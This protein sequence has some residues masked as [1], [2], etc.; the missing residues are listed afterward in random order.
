VLCHWKEREALYQTRE[1]RIRSQFGGVVPAYAVAT[2]GAPVDV[3]PSQPRGGRRGRVGVGGDPTDVSREEFD[4]MVRQLGDVDDDGPATPAAA[5][6]GPPGGRR[7]SRAA[8][9]AATTDDGDA[10][11]PQPKPKSPAARKTPRKHGR[12]R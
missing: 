9:K 1:K 6:A 2:G 11:R 3:A 7:G 8:G 5:P 4:E 12:A 10:P